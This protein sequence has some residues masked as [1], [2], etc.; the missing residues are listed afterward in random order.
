MGYFRT[1][2][3][4]GQGGRTFKDSMLD[5][6]KRGIGKEYP[7][8][9]AKGIQPPEPVGVHPPLLSF[10]SS[11]FPFLDLSGLQGRENSRRCEFSPPHLQPFVIHS[12][13]KKQE[14]KAQVYMVRPL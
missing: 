10:N 6:D 1:Y 7:C 13:D 14:L 3:D 5:K 12:R 8:H 2:R 4:T 11:L 9:A